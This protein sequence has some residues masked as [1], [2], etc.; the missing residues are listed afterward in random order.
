MH[1]LLALLW[2][3][4]VVMASTTETP[5]PAPNSVGGALLSTLDIILITVAV[6]LF[7]MWVTSKIVSEIQ[8]AEM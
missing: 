6:V 1:R 2:T 8:A 5:T 3:I 7:L 4:A